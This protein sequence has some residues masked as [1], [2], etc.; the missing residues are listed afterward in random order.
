MKHLLHTSATL[1][2]VSLLALGGTLASC[3]GDD[4]IN[5]D[6]PAGGEQTEQTS[7]GVAGSEN[8]V[9]PTRIDDDHIFTYDARGRVTDVVMSI[10]GLRY[11]FDYTRGTI[12]RTRPSST[13]GSWSHMYDRTAVSTFTLSP[14]GYIT[15]LTE[16]N[17]QDYG[18]ATNVA[19]FAYDAAGHATAITYKNEDM[20]VSAG[21]SYSRQETITLTWAADNLVQSVEK[22]THEDGTA[23]TST[24]TYTYGSKLP[25]LQWVNG[26]FDSYD[27]VND[28]FL[29]E[30]LMF[31][32]LLGLPSECQLMASTLTDEA[33]TDR[34]AYTYEM[35]A[36]GTVHIQ[37][38]ADSPNVWT[39]GYD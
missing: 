17:V 34:S 4:V 19:T 12:T 10:V 20:Y 5:P 8:L 22:R 26:Y 6:A 13:G 35:N 31:S 37:R 24:L 27:A 36:D 38:E 18:T 1:V 9:R 3:G 30:I 39:Y 2:A 29:Q 14:A 23:E 11:T 7:P 16:K 25:R 33:D 28:E 32:G 21:L 15:R